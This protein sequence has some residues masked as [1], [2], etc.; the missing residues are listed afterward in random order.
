MFY[1]GM[2]FL[3][4][5]NKGDRLQAIGGLNS[6]FKSSCFFANLLNLKLSSFKTGMNDEYMLNKT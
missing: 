5:T 2:L 3:D 4:K 1:S 6:A